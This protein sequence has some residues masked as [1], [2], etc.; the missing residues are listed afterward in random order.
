MSEMTEVEDAYI[1]DLRETIQYIAAFLWL[2]ASIAVDG[3]LVT[4][5][6]L[7]SGILLIYW[8]LAFHPDKCRIYVGES[9]L[10]WE[11]K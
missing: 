2:W 8:S 1:D 10:R 11:R 3:I 6:L 7:M 9:G 5:I 4:S